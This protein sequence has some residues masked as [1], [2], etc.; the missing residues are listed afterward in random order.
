MSSVENRKPFDAVEQH[1]LLENLIRNRGSV[2]NG[3]KTLAE[4]WQ[5][6][7]ANLELETILEF[8]LSRDLRKL[9]TWFGT[10][11]T[12]KGPPI[13]SDGLWFGLKVLPKGEL[14]IYAAVLARLGREPA[15]WDWDHVHYAKPHDAS[16]RIFKSLLSPKGPVRDEAVRRL[17]GLGCAV[18]VAQHL[19]HELRPTLGAREPVV[20][21]GFD[22]GEYFILGTAR[23][24]GRLEP[25][26][27]VAYS[28][29]RMGL[30]RGNLFRVADFAST[31]RWILAQPRNGEGK[32][33]GRTFGLQAKMA[34]AEAEI[35]VPVYIK[36]RRLDF[37]FTLSGVPVVRRTVAEVV[38]QTDRLAVQRLPVS[39]EGQ[40][41]DFEILNVLATVRPQRL[42]E[43]AQKLKQPLQE[44]D[45]GKHHIARVK[46]ILVVTRELAEHLVK[47]AVSGVNFIPL[48][49]QDLE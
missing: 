39:I 2:K 35:D 20:A 25:W 13:T 37:S 1:T 40:K 46:N 28:R 6:Q 14:D 23:V 38:E 11:W 24:N 18:L 12:G 17:M 19:C 26:P 41:G 22:E 16:S 32:E 43:Q 21:V 33:L 27:T 8:P 34:D 15:E 48:K 10:I 47:A 5:R 44:L 30:A 49:P 9:E 45:L 42:L 29:P 31:T 36:G 7:G 4:Y 3:L